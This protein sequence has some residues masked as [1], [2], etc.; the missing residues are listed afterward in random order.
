M[1]YTDFY[2]NFQQAVI[3]EFVVIVIYILQMYQA[4]PE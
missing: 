3:E 2:F 1:N 4:N